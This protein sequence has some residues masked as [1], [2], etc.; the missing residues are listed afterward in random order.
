MDPKNMTQKSLEAIQNAQKLALEHNNMQICPE[1]LFYALVADE[2]GLVPNI[3]TKLS[4][5]PNGVLDAAAELVRKIPG[6]TGS[7]REPDKITL[8]P[9]P[10]R[11]STPQ[12]GKPDA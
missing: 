9:K 11:Y 3:L 10:I 7:G 4:L 6:V 5:A 12:S 8:P 1:H 2:G